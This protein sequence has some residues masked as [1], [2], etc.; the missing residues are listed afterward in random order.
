MEVYKSWRFPQSALTCFHHSISSRHLSTFERNLTAFETPPDHLEHALAY[1]CTVGLCL[2]QCR[3]GYQC[4]YWRCFI[5]SLLS[6][7]H[8]R[9]MLTY[10]RSTIHWMSNHL[11]NCAINFLVGFGC[12]ITQTRRSTMKL[13]GGPLQM[14][15]RKLQL[16]GD[17]LR[18]LTWTKLAHWMIHLVKMV[19]TEPSSDVC[20]AIFKFTRGGTAPGFPQRNADFHFPVHA[21]AFR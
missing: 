7:P 8:Y 4:C 3:P 5:C 9:A 19:M 12:M 11:A 1:D 15:M 18:H 21:A 14:I 13:F 2:R 16:I 17:L 6:H 20:R 10:T